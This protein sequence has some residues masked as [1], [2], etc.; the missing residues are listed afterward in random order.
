MTGFVE[1]LTESLGMT[2]VHGE[3]ALFSSWGK[4]QL[5][6]IKTAGQVSCY[7][8][9]DVCDVFGPPSVLAADSTAMLFTKAAA[10]IH[11][12]AC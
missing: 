3:G 7:I 10:L 5:V 11:M 1:T 9:V 2:G 12:V 6:L 8:C 4:S